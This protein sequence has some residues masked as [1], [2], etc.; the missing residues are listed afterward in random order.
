MGIMFSNELSLTVVS[1]CSLK[2]ISK[3]GRHIFYL[4]YTINVFQ[5]YFLISVNEISDDLYNI[6]RYLL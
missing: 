3:H 6:H 2:L 5:I 4:E 1:K